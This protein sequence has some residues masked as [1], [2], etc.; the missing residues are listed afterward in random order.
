M[1]N[2]HRV[3]LAW[4]ENTKRIDNCQITHV[5]SVLDDAYFAI[6][7]DQETLKDADRPLINDSKIAQE[8]IIKAMEILQDL[9]DKGLS[10]LDEIATDIP[11]E[12]SKIGKLKMEVYLE[13]DR[14]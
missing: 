10:R 9:E 4:M 8:H 12:V 7:T 13:K 1:W 2:E 11:H 5:L 14:G 6:E 3:K